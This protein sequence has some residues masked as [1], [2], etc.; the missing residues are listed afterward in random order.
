MLHSRS[1]PRAAFTYDFDDFMVFSRAQL[2]GGGCGRERVSAGN[3]TS[4]ISFAPGSWH[5]VSGAGDVPDRTLLLRLE[6]SEAT[7]RS[8]ERD[9]TAPDRFGARDSVYHGRIAAAFDQL[10]S[11]SPGRFR[12]V[13]AGGPEED[14]TARLVAALEDLL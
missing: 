10:A 14:V 7:A 13:D 12:I 6:G 8:G 3:G 1:L 5:D 4:C 2:R 11:E 9:G